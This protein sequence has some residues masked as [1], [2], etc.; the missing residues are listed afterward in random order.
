MNDV[1]EVLISVRGIVL[2]F[3]RAL[4]VVL[5]LLHEQKVHGDLIIM[6]LLMTCGLKDP[7]TVLI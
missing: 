2:I 6:N 1:Y 7:I 5:E 3:K 4:S